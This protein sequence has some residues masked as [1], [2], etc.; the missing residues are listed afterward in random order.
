[1]GNEVY[2]VKSSQ[3][4][5]IAVARKKLTVNL[6]DKVVKRNRKRR[7]RAEDI[8][9]WY[10]NHIHDLRTFHYIYY[11]YLYEQI[12]DLRKFLVVNSIAA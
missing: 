6:E 12:Q 9:I 3:E 7:A 8:G 10:N 2:Y 5:G 4:I 11:S 1:M